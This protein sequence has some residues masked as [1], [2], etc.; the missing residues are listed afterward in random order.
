MIC[1]WLTYCAYTLWMK[2]PSK[3]MGD[4]TTID[5][6]LC[7][8]R[9]LFDLAMDVV[10]MRSTRIQYKDPDIIL[11]LGRLLTLCDVMNTVRA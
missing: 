5:E 2:L 7:E 3:E 1:V 8:I 4:E 11:Y 10:D 6:T 9:Q